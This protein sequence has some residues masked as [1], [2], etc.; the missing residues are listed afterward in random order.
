MNIG[1]GKFV[2]VAVAAG[3]DDIRDGRGVAIADLNNDGKLDIVINNNNATPTI[4]LNR[5]P[6]TGH[7]FR[8]MLV[9]APEDTRQAHRSSRDAL[10]AR[11]ALTMT[12]KGVSRQIVRWVEAGSGYA[13]QSETTLHFGLGE[14]ESIDE[15]AIAWP[16]GRLEILGRQQLQGLI[17]HEC[18]I[19]EGPGIVAV[20]S[21]RNER[22]NAI[23]SFGT[24]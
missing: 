21:A 9:G 20:R 18:T 19:R 6:N 14:A 4:Y 8:C 24:R 5:L 11:V 13:S 10:G 1:N 17:D 22:L 3:C 15:L 16:S 23:G 2:D 7:W 12:A